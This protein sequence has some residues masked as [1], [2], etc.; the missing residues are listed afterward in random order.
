[1]FDVQAKFTSNSFSILKKW[2]TKS[3]I[4]LIGR[5]QIKTTLNFIVKTAFWFWISNGKQHI[6]EFI[7]WSIRFL[8]YLLNSSFI[9]EARHIIFRGLLPDLPASVHAGSTPPVGGI[10]TS[11][12]RARALHHAAACSRHL[13][14][15]Q[16]LLHCHCCCRHGTIDWR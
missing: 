5:I 2:P 7:R 11:G 16:T 4:N 8:E 1:M 9:T 13:Y 10:R 15:C 6:L 14:F 12:Q 3:T